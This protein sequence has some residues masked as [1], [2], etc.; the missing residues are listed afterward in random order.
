MTAARE[1]FRRNAD[2]RIVVIGGCRGVRPEHISALAAR[3]P[4]RA[5]A[6]TP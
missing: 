2:G 5:R 1:I 4:R 6:S 3:L